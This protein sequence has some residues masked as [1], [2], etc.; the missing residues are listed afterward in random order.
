MNVAGS[1]GMLPAMSPKR[2]KKSPWKRL[3]QKRSRAFDAW[4]Q[5]ACGLRSNA[6]LIDATPAF[7]VAERQEWVKLMG[8]QVSGP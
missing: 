4:S 7:I 2:E 8:Y 6:D 3:S 5:D 1:A